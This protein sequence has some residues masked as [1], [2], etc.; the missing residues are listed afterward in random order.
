[1]GSEAGTRATALGLGGPPQLCSMARD[2]R[3]RETTQESWSVDPGCP[4]V[5]PL[6]KE[7]G[8]QRARAPGTWVRNTRFSAGAGSISALLSA[9]G[10]AASLLC[11]GGDSVSA[12]LWGGQRL[13]S[14]L[15]WAGGCLAYHGPLRP[16]TRMYTEPCQAMAM[17]TAHVAFLE[18]NRVPRALVTGSHSCP[19]ALGSHLL[20]TLAR[21]PWAPPPPVSGHAH[22]CPRSPPA[23]GL[24]ASLAHTRV[25]APAAPPRPEAVLQRCPHRTVLVAALLGALCPKRGKKNCDRQVTT[26]KDHQG[27]SSPRALNLGTEKLHVGFEC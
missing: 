12:L 1:M 4:V 19:A 14:A 11:S 17:D 18:K 16:R 13:S 2:P 7:T 23:G 3:C 22:V 20:G 9:G 24:R 15:G 27:L 6:H 8:T 21:L 25:C 10:G 26:V 5:Q